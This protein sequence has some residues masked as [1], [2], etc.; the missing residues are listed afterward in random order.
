MENNIIN[1]KDFPQRF[2]IQKH[3]GRFVNAGT[4]LES[5]FTFDE[6]KKLVKPDQ[7]ILEFNCPGGEKLWEIF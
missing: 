3:D 2:R 1:R 4:G 5:W 7:V 6:A